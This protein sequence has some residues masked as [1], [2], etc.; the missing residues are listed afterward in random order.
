MNVIVFD[1]IV[2]SCSVFMKVNYYI[3][4]KMLVLIFKIES[5]LMKAVVVMPWSQRCEESP[6]DK[7]KL[8][9]SGQT[10]SIKKISRKM[11][12]VC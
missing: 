9:S 4:K 8:Q 11:I 10:G 5:L 7:F 12:K 3:L 1:E 2:L 6:G